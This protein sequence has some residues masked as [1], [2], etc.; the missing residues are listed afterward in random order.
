MGASHDGAEQIRWRWCHIPK[1]RSRSKPLEQPK[2]TAFD[3]GNGFQL[4]VLTTAG[5]IML[6][7]EL[8]HR[9]WP[10]AGEI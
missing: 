8:A 4:Q 6:E 9:R 7:L 5:G 10:C 2:T 3:E 1:N